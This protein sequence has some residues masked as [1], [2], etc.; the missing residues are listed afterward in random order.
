MAI[1]LGMVSRRDGWVDGQAIPDLRIL[2]TSELIFSLVNA[3]KTLAARV[4]EL[5]AK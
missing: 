1:F 5:E 3:V 4:K 2:D